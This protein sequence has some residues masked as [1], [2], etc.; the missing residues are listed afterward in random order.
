MVNRRYLA[1]ALGSFLAGILVGNSWLVVRA[2]WPNSNLSAGI[3]TR[4]NSKARP[5]YALDGYCPVTLV[6]ESAWRPGDTAYL[7]T[8]EGATFLFASDEHRLAF[9]QSPERFAPVARGND[10]VELR[11]QGRE[12]RGQRKHGVTSDGRIYLFASEENL[13]R[14]YDAPNKYRQERRDVA[15]ASFED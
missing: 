7:A 12:V 4:P 3:P 15:Q 5:E 10:V 8:Y 11:D 13:N 1:V 2:V 9:Q 14:F 6:H